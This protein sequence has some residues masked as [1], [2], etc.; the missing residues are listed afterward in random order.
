[1]GSGKSTVGQELARRLDWTFIDLDQ[2]IERRE[3]KSIPDIFDQQ[4]EP[5]FRSAET[6]A[7]RELTQSLTSASVIALGGGAF[8]ESKNRELISIWPSVFLQ[9]SLDELWSRCSHDRS[10][11]PLR[12]DRQQFSRL[13]EKRLPSYLEATVTVV[14]SDRDI[15]SICSEIEG[16]LNLGKSPSSHGLPEASHPANS[17]PGGSR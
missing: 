15:P 9:A 4:G 5:G 6:A 2:Q 1:M 13:Y 11:R 8:G 14:T 3:R 17:V 7:L 16:K 10:I 12:N